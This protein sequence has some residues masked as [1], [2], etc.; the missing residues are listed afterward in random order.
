MRGDYSRVRSIRGPIML[1]TV[2]VLFALQNF[3]A[4]GFEQTWPVLLIVLGLLHLIGRTA[5]PQAPEPPPPPYNFPPAGSRPYAQTGYSQGPQPG[6]TQGTE[7]G[8]FGGS[9]NPGGAA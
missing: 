2:G 3:T 9:A 5:A 8:G 6:A 1:I 4:F 7:K